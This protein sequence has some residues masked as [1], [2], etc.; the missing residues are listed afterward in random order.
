MYHA[1]LEPWCGVAY[2]YPIVCNVVF[3]YMSKIRNL[4]DFY[5]FKFKLVLIS[6]FHEATY[7]PFIPANEAP[8]SR[9]LTALFVL[10]S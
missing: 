7:W 2:T 3:E 5:M 6:G 9:I 4:I 8:S 1:L 10:G